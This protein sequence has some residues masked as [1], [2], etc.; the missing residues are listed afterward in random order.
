LAKIDP[1]DFEIIGL[2]EMVKDKQINKKQK[3][4]AQPTGL[5]SAAGQAR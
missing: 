3:Q 2:T 5:L 4:N 1:A